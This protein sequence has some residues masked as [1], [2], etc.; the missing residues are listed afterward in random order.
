MDLR[1]LP[2]LASLCALAL[3]T[4]HAAP[5]STPNSNEIAISLGSY[6]YEEPGV[7]SL[8][9]IKTGIDLRMT[10]SNENQR[11][12]FRTELRYAA[13]TVDYSSIKTGSASGEP[14]WYFEGRLLAGSDHPQA[15]ALFS[16]YVGLGYRFL[17]NDGRGLTTTNA[18]G[19]RRESN[20]FYLPL[21]FTYL[22][23]LRNGN[24]LKTMLEYDHLLSGHQLSRLS[25]T[26]LGYPDLN[27]QQNSG[28]GVKLRLT[29]ATR[30]WSLGPYLHYWN[31]AAS[32]PVYFQRNGSSYSGVEPKNKTTEFGIEFARPF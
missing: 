7:M 28:Y 11:V 3:S 23:D 8:Q 19:Y 31:I 2:L 27:N 1:R 18:A 30:E 22:S 21:G 17:F 5:L 10:R 16:T 6:R 20:Y 32:E 15:H 14:D 26:G 9:G 12:F 4:A 13:G 24:T 25:D 29:Y